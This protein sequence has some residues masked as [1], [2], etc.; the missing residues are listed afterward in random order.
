MCTITFDLKDIL[1]M[2]SGYIL[3]WLRALSASL[4]IISTFVC[5]LNHC[6][7]VVEGMCCRC[8][9]SFSFQ[10]AISTRFCVSVCATMEHLSN[11]LTYCLSHWLGLQA[12]SPTR[13]HG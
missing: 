1:H 5:E 10:S 3:S 8:T 12:Q 4:F 6:V 7:G 11:H 2:H 13:D 9:V